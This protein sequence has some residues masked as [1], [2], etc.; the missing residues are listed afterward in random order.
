MENQLEKFLQELYQFDPSLEQ[1]D[2]DLRTIISQMS[3]IRP[4]T[5]FS[6][7]LA[8]RVKSVLMEQVSIETRP[9]SKNNYFKFNFINMNKKLYVYGGVAAVFV[10]AL[11]AINMNLSKVQDESKISI[12]PT[13][14]SQD[15][16][17][18]NQ[19]AIVRLEASAFGSLASV[20]MG[21]GTAESIEAMSVENKVSFAS[22]L[23]PLGLGGDTVVSSEPMMVEG[24]SSE[25]KM[26]MPYFNYK[27]VYRGDKVNLSE[28]EGDVY[29]R[30]TVSSDDSN[31]LVSLVSGLNLNGL[32]LSSFNN[33]KM[34]NL[35]LM[36]DKDKGLSISFD[37]VSGT[38]SVYENWQK[39]RL[40]ERENCAGDQ[41]CWNRWRLQISDV[42]QDNI[43]I[44]LANSFI[45]KHQIEVSSYGSPVVD[46][47]WR[48]EYARSED[49]ANFYIPEYASVVYPYLVDG[50]A[51][52]DQS[53]NYA[54]MR[55]SINLVHQA[56]SG[57]SNLS[58]NRYEVSSYPLVTDF[59]RIVRQ[60]ENGGWNGSH[61]YSPENIEEIAL[62]TPEKIYVQLWHY[63]HDS[64][65]ELLIPALLFPVLENE[66]AINNQYYGQRFVMIPLVVDIFSE[67]ESRQ[68]NI[69]DGGIEITPYPVPM[70][71]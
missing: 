13:N 11:V 30:L 21:G 49:K 35:S 66:G 58:L 38:V 4:D 50:V 69:I 65:D 70:L 47:F 62:G 3:I 19:D 39:W 60:A 68:S 14:Y 42:P 61:F 15:L 53:G 28:T 17:G 41:D 27:Y 57:L 9:V 5:K 51:V 36:E 67:L 6:P 18:Q 52:K 24:G 8:K 16:V 37:F 46:N 23:A 45:N 59:Q 12:Q 55:V 22:P 48:N 31:S 20:S 10:F 34:Q 2:H 56:V 7:E 71:R 26:I 1:F 32:S 54:G 63:S 25:L 43:L 44:T 64:S 40:P 33:L 29:K